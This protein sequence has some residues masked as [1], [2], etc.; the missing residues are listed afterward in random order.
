MIVQPTTT[1]A[2]LIVAA[3][4]GVRAGSGGLA[5]Q[6][7]LIGGRP[8]LTY[9]LNAFLEHPAIDS[10]QV[11]IGADDVTQYGSLAPN[12]EQLLPPVFGADT[13]Q[14]SVLAGLT[15]LAARRPP[16]R[17]LIHDAARPF[18]S[19][20]LTTR[21][22]IGL[23][24]ADA[25]V[26]TLPV[27]ST[28][29]ALDTEAK[30][31]ATVPRD[32]LHT[33]ET[34]QGFTFSRILEAQRK[35][36]SA[37]RD[38]TDDAAL[39]EWAG[40]PVV[41]I[42]GEVANIKLTSAA[43]IAAADRRL[44]GEAMLVTGDIRVGMGYDVH[45]LGPGREVMLGGI[46]IPHTHALIGHSDADVGLHALTDAVLGALA[47]GDIGAHFPPSDPRWKDVSSDRFLA[48]AARRVAGRG[49]TIAH[50]DLTLIAEA[51]KIGPHRDAMRQRISEIC[52]ISLERVGVKATTN[53][54]LGFLGR[55]EGIA[56]HASATLR[57][58]VRTSS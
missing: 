53:E 34:P 8:M 3:G 26:P 45:A 36:V 51:P 52:Q 55:G 39:A 40:I 4:R 44:A 5:K 33:A 25:I 17:V 50:L 30:V 41:A 14:G 57:L 58:P 27:T 20:D 46:A 54:G 49:G 56:A 2:A 18:A 9:C 22:V 21:V 31:T 42:P 32:G 6:Y 10:V 28:L 19:P 12:S 15:A 35:A 43:D 1:T 16:D 13:R 7:Q 23:D 11:V 48:E 47:D 24:D 37:R 29:K 38:F